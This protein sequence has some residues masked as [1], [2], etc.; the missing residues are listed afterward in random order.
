MTWCADKGAVNIVVPLGDAATAW[1]WAG[2]IGPFKIGL[3]AERAGLYTRCNGSP[4]MMRAKSVA[5]KRLPDHQVAMAR[6]R[7]ALTAAKA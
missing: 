2:A 7:S 6:T 1:K 3:G 4:A 5:G